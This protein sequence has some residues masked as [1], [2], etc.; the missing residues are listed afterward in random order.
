MSGPRR[1]LAT[2]LLLSLLLHGL[3]LWRALA[4]DAGSPAKD[5]ELPRLQV[6][7]VEAPQPR[8]AA[9]A[10][11]TAPS[12]TS[13]AAHAPRPTAGRPRERNALAP[14]TGPADSAVS[15]PVPAATAP[16]PA[17]PATAAAQADA[18]DA[19]RGARA[20]GRLLDSTAGREAVRSAARQDAARPR[21]QAPHEDPL[22]SGLQQAAH[23]DCMKGEFKGG[24]WAC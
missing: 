23:G 6:V 11:A 8:L 3:L 21:I 7:W 1:R 17:L 10:P 24:A 20:M 19:H 16:E 5:M 13:T 18:A 22:A 14:P 2:G 9:K 4:P 12:A 15:V